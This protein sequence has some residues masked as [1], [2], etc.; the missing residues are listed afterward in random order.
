MVVMKIFSTNIN[1]YNPNAKNLDSNNDIIKLSGKQKM[2]LITLVSKY[3]G[4]LGKKLNEILEDSIVKRIPKTNDYILD[5]ENL[6]GVN[7]TDFKVYFRKIR[8]L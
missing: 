7:R 2:T 6:E 3:H 8:V 1:K 5:Y 4:L